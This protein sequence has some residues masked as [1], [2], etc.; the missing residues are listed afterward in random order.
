MRCHICES[1]TTQISE[2]NNF[3][4]NVLGC[5]KWSVG[6]PSNTRAQTEGI[7]TMDV[8]EDSYKAFEMVQ[9]WVNWWPF[10][11]SLFYCILITGFLTWWQSPFQSS[12]LSALYWQ[13]SWCADS[14]LSNPYHYQHSTDRFPDVLSHFQSSPLSAL[15]WQVS[16][17][18][19][20]HLSNPYH[21]Q[22]STDRFSD[23]LTV[24]F[25][26]LTTISTHGRL[27][28]SPQNTDIPLQPWYS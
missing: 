22:H 16:W 1:T 18:N 6:K 26:T 27:S 4:C 11:V 28:V 19:D 12:P 24:S 9:G 14:H 3:V 25:P 8:T 23:V 13:D 5:I 7:I 2:I 17:Y 21:Y 15:Y 20:S 10:L